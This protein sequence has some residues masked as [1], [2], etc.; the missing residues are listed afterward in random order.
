MKV[1]EKASEMMGG[2]AEWWAELLTHRTSTLTSTTKA[3]IN[4]HMSTLGSMKLQ[5]YLQ[6][7][8]REPEQTP[9]KDQN[10]RRYQNRDWHGDYG[11]GRDEHSHGRGYD[12]QNDRGR[13]RARDWR[14]KRDNK[15][16]KGKGNGK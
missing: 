13:D 1:G 9:T 11:R 12:R 2:D 8:L 7:R 5:A 4:R 15:R 10:D 16:P 3:E 14:E 6:G